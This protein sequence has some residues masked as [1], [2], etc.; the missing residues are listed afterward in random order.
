MKSASDAAATPQLSTKSSVCVI[1]DC[2]G[3]GGVEVHTIA[4]IDALLKS[5]RVQRDLHNDEDE[6][7]K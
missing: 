4:L 6:D 2:R 7:S 5:D 3:F 1:T